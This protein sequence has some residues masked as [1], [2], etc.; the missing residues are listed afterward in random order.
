MARWVADRSALND[1]LASLRALPRLALDTEFERIRTYWP[2]LALFQ[3]MLPDGAAL[4]DPL[5]FDALHD[6]GDAI[7]Q[8]AQ[9]WLMHSPSEDL[10][11]LAPLLP[12]PPAAL[13][14]TQLA[15]AL[16]GLGTG[17]GYQKLVALVLGVELE[18]T[19][20]RSDW[21]RRPLSD[22][23]IA[24]AAD[25]VVHLDA[26]GDALLDKLDALNRRDWIAQEG[27]RTLQAAFS[28]SESANLHHDYRSAW[29]L[30]LDA[31]RRLDAVLRWREQVARDTDRPKPWVIDNQVAHD[32]AAKPPTQASEVQRM[33]QAQ[34][35]FPRSKAGD[36]LDL[37]RD[38][39]V[40]AA[41]LPAPKPFS[42]D[43][44][45]ALERLKAGI[46]AEAES[47][48]IE[49]A[50]LAPR[51]AQEARLRRGTWPADLPEWRH[52]RLDAIAAQ[53]LS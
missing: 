52:D 36:L 34:R 33:L 8:P 41:F 30:D 4:I 50:L 24:Y 1:A 17:L 21:M 19:E 45:V 5:A 6:L 12:R 39:P 48:A 23:Q 40:H 22:N 3:A 10:V 29:K 7:S 32:L 20:T 35:A 14:D 26:L 51:K 13:F 25:D 53:A 47:L 43:E 44:E 28:T 2:K 9:T 49:P 31:Q 37:L 42:R 16:A 18:K 15:A 27:R 46:E 38:P 11:A